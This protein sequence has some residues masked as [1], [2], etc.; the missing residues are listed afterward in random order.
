MRPVQRWN[1][2][3]QRN[4]EY[5]EKNKEYIKAKAN[6]YYAENRE[7][8]IKR[9]NKYERERRQ[10]DPIFRL[11][12]NTKGSVYKALKRENGGKNGSKTL[13]A[14]PFTVDQLKEHLESQF[15]EHMSWDNYGDYWHVDHIYPLALLPYDSLEHPHF[16]LVWD[17]N[18]LRPLNGKEN[19]SK[20]DE[21]PEIIPEHIKNFLES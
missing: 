11:T 7:E 2:I 3:K 12:L 6:D 1:R 17:L 18:N 5:Y 20:G 16:A 4:K 15:D 10:R 8:C 9:A 19:I 13:D 21:I 14:L